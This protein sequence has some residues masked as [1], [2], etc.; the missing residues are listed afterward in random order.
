MFMQRIKGELYR[1]TKSIHNSNFFANLWTCIR[2]VLRS[3][4]TTLCRISWHLQNRIWMLVKFNLRGY[5]TFVFILL[6][7]IPRLNVY[8][9]LQYL[10]QIRK[11]FFLFLKGSDTARFE[12]V[13]PVLRNDR[14]YFVEFPAATSE[15]NALK[16]SLRRYVFNSPSM[17]PV[18]S[19]FFLDYIP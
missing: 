12:H 4:P 6:S 16:L 8:S 13:R 15:L 9:H 1:K 5:Y 2:S 17:L 18:S 3:S 19:I 10:L 11:K 7:F 14:K